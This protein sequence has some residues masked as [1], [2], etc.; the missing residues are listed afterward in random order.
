[1]DSKKKIGSQKLLNNNYQPGKFPK[2]N[3]LLQPQDACWKQPAVCLFV[4]GKTTQ[5]WT[6]KW[7]DLEKPQTYTATE[8]SDSRCRRDSHIALKGSV[9]LNVFVKVPKKPWTRELPVEQRCPMASFKNKEFYLCLNTFINSA[10]IESQRK[11]GYDTSNILSHR[12]CLGH[13]CW[14]SKNIVITA[15]YAE[16]G[17]VATV[18]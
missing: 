15:A 7:C 3:G 16:H 14:K 13:F 12:G 8:P 6:G 5:W 4:S 11:H 17:L 9:P 1:M 10:E 18:S 2:Q